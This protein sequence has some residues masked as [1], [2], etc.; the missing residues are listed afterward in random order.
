MDTQ[1]LRLKVEDARYRASE[2]SAAAEQAAENSQQR[3]RGARSSARERDL[4]VYR[5][6]RLVLALSHAEI[7]SLCSFA[8]EG[9][10]ILDEEL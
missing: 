5:Y 9:E 4:H 10:L 1:G 7:L 8:M 3:E 6:L 2:A